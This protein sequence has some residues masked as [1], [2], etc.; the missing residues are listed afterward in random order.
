MAY[1][2]LACATYAATPHT[3]QALTCIDVYCPHPSV[4]VQEVLQVAKFRPKDNLPVT[5]LRHVLQ[6]GAAL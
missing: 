6:Q 2:L 1:I 4:L 5:P 3:P